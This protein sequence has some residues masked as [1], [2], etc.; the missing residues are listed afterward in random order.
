M[1]IPDQYRNILLL[2]TVTFLGAFLA[3][4]AAFW[5]EPA[6]TEPK[7]AALHTG[8]TPV[9]IVGPPF[10]PNTNPRER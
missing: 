4:G 8:Q 3:A 6:R 1:R 2:G 5:D 9:R 10:V 7:K